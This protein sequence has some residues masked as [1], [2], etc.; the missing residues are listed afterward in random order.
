MK[1]LL[2]SLLFV[3]LLTLF[4]IPVMVSS[5]GSEFQSGW[6]D[7]QFIAEKVSKTLDKTFDKDIREIPTSQFYQEFVDEMGRTYSGNL[8][9]QELITENGAYKATYVGELYSN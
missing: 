4:F 6:Q 5:L 2:F 3:S 9:L 8:I 7:N 1:K